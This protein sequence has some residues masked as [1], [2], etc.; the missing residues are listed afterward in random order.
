M[1]LLLAGYAQHAAQK[2]EDNEWNAAF[3]KDMRALLDVETPFVDSELLAA[4]LEELDLEEEEV[5]E[6]ADEG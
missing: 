3:R 5:E 4:A 1:R 6:A 2:N